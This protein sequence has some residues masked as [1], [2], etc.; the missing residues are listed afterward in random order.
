VRFAASMAA[1]TVRIADAQPKLLTM[2]NDKDVSVRVGVA[3]RGWS[4][5]NETLSRAA[6]VT[7]FTVTDT[8]IGISAEK[9]KIIFEAFQQADAS[10]S[11]KYGGTGLGLAISRELATLLGGEIRLSSILGQGSTF[12]LFL[13]LTYSEPV[14][15]GLWRRSGEP[16]GV[17]ALAVVAATNP[18]VIPDDRANIGEGDHVLLI[19]EDDSHYARVLLGLAR[20]KGF[21]GLVAPRGNIGLELAREYKPAAI[22]LDIFLPDMLGWTVLNN[23]KRDPATRH[24]PVQIISVE[25]ERQHGL[26][27]GAFAYMVKPATTDDLVVAFGVHPYFFRVLFVIEHELVVAAIVF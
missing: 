24:I 7:A 23:L 27:H 3:D 4:P 9:Q 2:V 22:T 25:E 21:K 20:D 15:S 19:I 26:S 1:G 6:S 10:T 16:A 13:P 18:E 8:G 14:T 17:P 5:A 11:R 12:T